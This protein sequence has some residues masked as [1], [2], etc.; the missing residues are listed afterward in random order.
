MGISNAN[1]ALLLAAKAAG[2]KFGRMATFGK[3]MF[4]PTTEGLERILPAFGVRAAPNILRDQMGSDGDRFLKFLGAESVTS[5]DVSG[6]EGADVVHDMNEPLPA[7]WHEA[8]D[9]LYDG[10]CIEHI[11]HV[12]QV[13]E[14]IMSLVKPGGAFIGCTV[15]NNLM[16]HG[17]YQFSPE[18]YFRVFSAAN[19]WEVVGILLCEHEKVPPQF[20]AVADP[21]KVGGRVELQNADAVYLLVVARKLR[22]IS[23]FVVPQ[24][25]DYVSAWKSSFSVAPRTR[26]QSLLRRVARFVQTSS[27]PTRIILRLRRNDGL[28]RRGVTQRCYHRRSLEDLATGRIDWQER[29]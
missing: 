12:R 14:N 4:W 23:G 5:F 8:F 29:P 18:F 10:G 26:K 13:V 3:Q 9:S 25:S 6:Y 17:F 16:G 24:Q 11:F 21:A 19:G 20:W 22:S 27:N 15:G 1:T 7:V 2:I 28:S